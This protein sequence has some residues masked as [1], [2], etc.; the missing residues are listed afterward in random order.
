MQ[1]FNSENWLFNEEKDLRKKRNSG[2]S[3]RS[4]QRCGAVVCENVGG[5]RLLGH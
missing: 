5:K 3:G 4:Q 2:S 1:I